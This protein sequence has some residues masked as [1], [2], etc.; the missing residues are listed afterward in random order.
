MLPRPGARTRGFA[1]V[2]ASDQR[3]WLQHGA[4]AA[5]RPLT[6]EPPDGERWAHGGLGASADGAW[7]VAVREVHGAEGEGAHGTR[8]PRRCVVALGT[9]PGHAGAS[10][11]AQGHDFYG[12]PRL[13]TA[14]QRLAV[15]AWDHPDMPWDRSAVIV[16]ALACTADATTGT[17]RLVPAGE[18]WTGEGGVDVSV[19]QPRWQRDGCGFKLRR[20]YSAGRTAGQPVK[21]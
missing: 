6:P 14:T 17:S 19:G 12:A 5:P 20:T 11:L 16:V 8:S 18:P 9:G 10:V 3:V 7:V 4:G 21:R 13:D 1:Y 15:V 2:G